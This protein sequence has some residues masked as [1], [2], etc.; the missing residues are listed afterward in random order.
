LVFSFPFWRKIA[1]KKNGYTSSDGLP[2]LPAVSLPE[3]SECQRRQNKKT[4]EDAFIV[5]LLFFLPFASFS[6]ECSER[7]H[8]SIH[9]SAKFPIRVCPQILA[10]EVFFKFIHRQVHQET[11]EWEHGEQR[12]GRPGRQK[13]V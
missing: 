13:R 5:F 12:S 9:R 1:N 2:D 4:A 10:N 3:E 11:E 8:R 6:L 7:H